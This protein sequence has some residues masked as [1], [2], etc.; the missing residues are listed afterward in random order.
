MIAIQL[1]GKE[2]QLAGPVTLQELLR[3]VSSTM[4]IAVAINSEI[5]PRSQFEKVQVRDR[6]RVEIIHAVGG[7]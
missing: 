4:T 1:N 5:I 7:G 3:E 6:D 2:R